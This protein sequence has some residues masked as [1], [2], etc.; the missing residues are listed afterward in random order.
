MHVQLRGLLAVLLLGT[1]HTLIVFPV[2]CMARDAACMCVHPCVDF[3]L[4]FSTVHTRVTFSV[5]CVVRDA[6]YVCS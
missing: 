2:P 6:V 3:L 5:P 4:L 1:A